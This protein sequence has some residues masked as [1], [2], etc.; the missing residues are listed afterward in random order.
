MR[1]RRFP[2]CVALVLAAAA[3]LAAAPPRQD[4]RPAERG[5]PLIRLFDETDHG[6]G[7]Q[8][9]GVTTDARGY[10]YIGNLEGVLI[11]DGARWRLAE[12]ETAGYH[13]ATGAAGHVLVGGPQS[14]AILEARKTGAPEL[15]SLVPLLPESEREFGD[16]RRIAVTREGFAILT[17]AR[18]LF[19]DGS[20]LRTLDEWPRDAA[21]SLLALGGDAYLHGEGAFRRVTG[22]GLAPTD[23]LAPLRQH[24]VDALIQDEDGHPDLAVVRDLGLVRLE[25]PR[26]VARPGLTSDWARK[27]IV[28][29]ALRL[30]DGRIA[31]GSRAG[32]VLITNAEGEA[33]QVIDSARGLPDDQVAQLAEDREGGLWVA[34]NMGLARLDIA[35]TTTVFDTRAGVLAGS[36]GVGRHGGKLYAFG[37][38]GLAVLRDGAFRK[39]PGIAGSTWSGL[40]LPDSPGEFLVAAASGIFSVR[41]DRAT[42]VPG[43][44]DRSVYVLARSANSNAVLVGARSGL[45]LLLR[46]GDKPRLIG[47]IAGS[48]RYVRSIVTRPSGRVFLGTVFDGVVAAD[49]DPNRP[50]A[51]RFQKLGGYES[52]VHEGPDGPRA[53]T[54]DETTGLFFIDEK[55]PRLIEDAVRTRALEDDAAWSSAS[56][57][58]GSLWV[59]TTPVRVFPRVNGQLSD[60]PLILHAFPARRVQMFRPESDGVMWAGTDDGLFRHVGPPGDATAP[61]TA[62]VIAVIAVEDQAIFDGWSGAT[63]LPATLP[64]H[65]RRLRVEFGPLSHERGLAF[66]FRLRP[67]DQDWSEWSTRSSV[68]FTTLQEGTYHFEAR[69]RGADGRVGPA[70]DWAFSIAPPWHRSWGAQLLGL[71]LL[72]LAVAVAIR[73]RTRVLRREAR[74][75]AERVQ[76]RTRDLEAAVRDLEAVRQRVEEQNRLLEEANARLDDVSRHDSLTGIANRRQ[77]D[78]AFEDE[79]RR[80]RREGTP[81]VVG[82]LDLDHFKALNDTCGHPEG[83]RALKNVAATL[84]AALRRPGDTVARYGG[85]EF[86]FILPGTR[87]AGA[88]TVAEDVR[89]RIEALR[90]ANPGSPLG[91]L[92][93]SIGLVEATPDESLEPQRLLEAADRALYAAKSEGRN[94]VH[95]E[96]VAP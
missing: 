75:L 37:S 86:A 29:C 65:L 38:G 23:D 60:V 44:G 32:G 10:V 39:I 18:L 68:E 12:S 31:F 94:R 47:P 27:N 81:L 40:D 25:G 53:T 90:F 7:T 30:R 1:P 4:P 8:N 45:H 50:D 46:T 59:N 85:E 88:L 55:A 14:L 66:Q 87:L 83:D 91:H 84:D 69:T 26:L 96:T 35:S 72:G 76:E 89:A 63:P 92:T 48:P 79:W 6:A 41:N 3:T 22:A 16:V 77:F 49:F 42:L 13:I 56:D 19:Y 21:R 67:V 15:R 61:P 80:A 5:F 36:Q 2:V 9:F 11:W 74:R 78:I 51:A 57:R 24:I 33:E 52:E 93:A 43:T 95:G 70:V 73:L 62:P 28:S 71:A 82:M 54:S 34:L 20:T 64:T 58:D 17:D